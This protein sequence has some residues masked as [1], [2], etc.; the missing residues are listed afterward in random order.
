M[1]AENNVVEDSATQFDE[2]HYRIREGVKECKAN[3][4]KEF[5]CNTWQGVAAVYSESHLSGECAFL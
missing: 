5:Q 4:C 3:Q 2:R 1:Y